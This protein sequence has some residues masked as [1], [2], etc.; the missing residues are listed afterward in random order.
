MVPILACFL[1]RTIISQLIRLNVAIELPR[2]TESA[3][4][5]SIRHAIK[6]KG[7]TTYQPRAKP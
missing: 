5:H 4:P 3:T 1:H 6:A 7:P 2:H